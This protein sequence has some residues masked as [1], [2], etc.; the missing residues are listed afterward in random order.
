[1]STN[2]EHYQLTL[3]EGTDIFNPLSTNDNFTKID[4]LLYNGVSG[5]IMT[6]TPA[7]SGNTMAFTNLDTL[8]VGG[9]VK[10][11]LTEVQQV[12]KL[13]FGGSTINIVD[14]SG[15]VVTLD[16]G[17]WLGYVNSNSTFRAMA[18]P[19][20]VDAATLGGQTKEY[21]ATAEAAAAA[22]SAA[23]QANQVAQAATTVANQALEAAQGVGGW[24]LIIAPQLSN[25]A[26]NSLLTLG[27]ISEYKAIAIS[28]RSELDSN[29][30]QWK[31][32]IIPLE[33]SVGTSAAVKSAL[34]TDYINITQ[35]VMRDIVFG[36]TINS[37]TIHSTIASGGT[38]RLSPQRVYGIK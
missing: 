19:M 15:E 1:M 4:E 27:D 12:N 14:L 29:A 37:A 24:T 34:A 6:G 8:A 35:L 25:W 10:F 2:T 21:F 36:G 26:L 23:E 7:V 31:T 9:V 5:G 20:A 17:V 38:N 22:A 30:S 3:R 33:G 18:W 28:L 13:S 16:A 32:L 11:T